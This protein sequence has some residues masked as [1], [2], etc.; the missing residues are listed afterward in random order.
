MSRKISSYTSCGRN[1]ISPTEQRS[2]TL[3]DN[4]FLELSVMQCPMEKKKSWKENETKWKKNST[5]QLKMMIGK[6]I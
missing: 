1:T 2:V 4:L 3:A 6:I 5:C